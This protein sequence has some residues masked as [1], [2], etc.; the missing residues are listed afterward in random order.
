MSDINYRG[1]KLFLHRGK[2]DKYSFTLLMIFLNERL[3]SLSKIVKIYKKETNTDFPEIR[4]Q[5]GKF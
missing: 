4:M 5:I 2:F 1:R 3:K